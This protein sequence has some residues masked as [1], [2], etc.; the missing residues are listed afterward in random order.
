MSELTVDEIAESLDNAIS[1]LYPT[2]TVAVLARDYRKVKLELA[3][4]DQTIAELRSQVTLERNEH[5]EAEAQSLS[6]IRNMREEID[7]REREIAE[8]RSQVSDRLAEL[9][10]VYAANSAN[11]QLYREA[12]DKRIELEREITQLRESLLVARL[13]IKEKLCKDCKE[14]VFGSK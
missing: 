11:A 6:K 14:R 7:A 9:Q 8:L 2:N 1:P 5:A 12:D 10:R 4:R 13:E 3:K